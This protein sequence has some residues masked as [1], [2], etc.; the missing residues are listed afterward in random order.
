MCKS[1]FFTNLRY[2]KKVSKISKNIKD[3]VNCLTLLSRP[4]CCKDHSN[5]PWSF[6]SWTLPS[7]LCR[8]DVDIR[9]SR[10]DWAGPSSSEN[11]YSPHLEALLCYTRHQPP[12]PIEWGWVTK[13]SF[14][15]HWQI[16]LHIFMVVLAYIP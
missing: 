1:S 4:S 3:K 2:L 11:L 13:Q 5:H 14:K 7:W 15:Q 10:T 8:Y 12:S 6:H 16:Q 9:I